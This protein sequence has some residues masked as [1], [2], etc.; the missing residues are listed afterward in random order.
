MDLDDYLIGLLQMASEL[1]SI[2]LSSSQLPKI[3]F[4]RIVFKLIV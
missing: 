4:E 3:V 2:Y 1:V